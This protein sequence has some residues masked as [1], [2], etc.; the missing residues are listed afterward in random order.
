[1]KKPSTTAAPRNPPK[2][3]AITPKIM[4]E[5]TPSKVSQF[6]TYAR[7]TNKKDS[8]IDRKNLVWS[9]P[10]ENSKNTNSVAKKKKIF[11]CLSSTVKH[12]GLDQFHH[13]RAS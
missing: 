7:E 8:R 12:R 9:D 5:A 3:R 4:D 11:S 13:G 10:S 1:M 6:N 2:P